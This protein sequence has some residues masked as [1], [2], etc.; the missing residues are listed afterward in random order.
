VPDD[1]AEDCCGGRTRGMLTRVQKQLRGFGS[2]EIT[3]GI[4][5]RKEG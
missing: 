4:D 1:E 5:E 2:V 3:S